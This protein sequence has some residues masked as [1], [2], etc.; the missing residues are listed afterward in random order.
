[1]SP[2]RPPTLP[3]DGQFIGQRVRV[4]R[5]AMGLSQRQL[6]LATG[7]YDRTY[8]AHIE[9]GNKP[10]QDRDLLYRLA[11]ALSV[12]VP[13]LTGQPYAP[14][15]RD[16]VAARAAVV[17]IEHALM[18]AGLAP[19]PATLR[20]VEDLTMAASMAMVQ[21]MHGDYAALGALAPGVITE[22][23]AHTGA[24]T[25]P[26]RVAAALTR[27]LFAV[28]I[29]LKEQ[30]YTTLAY[31]AAQQ[32][33]QAA[34]DAEHVA[35]AAYAQSQVLLAVA[36]V[37]RAAQVAADAADAAHGTA[38]VGQVSALTQMAGMLHLQ[39]A[40]C[41]TALAQRDGAAHHLDTAAAHLDE[42][43]D[44]ASHTAGGSAFALMFG[45]TNVTVWEMSLA[46]ERGEAAQVAA[47]AAQVDPTKLTTPNRLSRFHLER[48]RAYARSKQ[49]RPE[50]LAALLAAEKAA[51][52]YVQTRPVV[53]E[54]A[55]FLVRDARRRAVP[56]ALAEFA[57]RV[58]AVA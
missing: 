44:L 23:H 19:P 15:G 16:Q 21:R 57:S 47:L 49:H 11:A 53:R 35:A 8:I 45:P 55:G 1:M 27:V 30:G 31:L 13:E 48:A 4:L 22:L 36:A 5:R 9:A 17:R 18:C 39:T 14:A 2:S 54:L 40:L 7:N 56:D 26:E 25:E 42:A 32:A 37:D 12:S 29:G 43:R 51:P 41:R 3:T 58:G 24:G 52:H 33:A 6:A 28:S 34:P 38:Q 10:V 20:P 46:V 50:A